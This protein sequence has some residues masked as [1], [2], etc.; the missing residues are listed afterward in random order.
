M[1][2][3]Y[4]SVAVAVAAIGTCLF[5]A[6]ARAQFTVQTQRIGTFMAEFPDGPN[7]PVNRRHVLGTD[8][9]FTATWRGQGIMLF[10]DSIPSEESPP[11]A[12]VS[13]INHDDAWG[14][15]S[16]ANSSR[17]AVPTFYIYAKTQR[18]VTRATG[19]INMAGAR[20]PAGI[21]S[22]NESYW[23]G[24]F[25]RVGAF[26]TCSN[27]SHCQGL[28]CDTGLR[29]Y[30]PPSLP[31]LVANPL[32]C[33][34]ANPACAQATP[35]Q[36]G[37]CRDTSTSNPMRNFVAP[38]TP[39]LDTIGVYALSQSEQRRVL[40]VATIHQFGPNSQIVPTSYTTVP[41]LTNKF[42]NVTMRATR[43]LADYRVPAAEVQNDNTLWVWGRPSYWTNTT[44]SAP[45]DVFLARQYRTSLP[46]TGDA[47]TVLNLVYRKSDGTWSTNQNDAAKLTATDGWADGVAGHLNFTFIEGA[48][49]WLMTYGGGL[50]TAFDSVGGPL[51]VTL[52]ESV[53]TDGTI[54]MRIADNPW[55]PWSAPVTALGPFDAS[56]CHQLHDDNLGTGD[57]C[58]GNNLP[59]SQ[60]SLIFGPGSLYGANV[61]E[62]WTTWSAATRNA[63][64][65]WVV[66]TWNPY[67]VHQMKSTIH[68]P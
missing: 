3:T 47:T 32:I 20:T 35:G 53:K 14:F 38:A 59:P 34:A 19:D 37:I 44:A 65:G 13:D 64:I 68:I 8:M 52:S 61:I 54:K 23:W 42:T 15:W 25:A 45:A 51:P 30:T 2:H 41:W 40:T 17:N 60:F 29:A 66:S 56:I 5:A 26:R 33:V 50:P 39:Y 63:E 9:G 7:V 57:R 22:F 21:A 6:G 12:N 62:G 24:L 67:E 58:G 1:K 28:A 46:A 31:G 48:N 18:V 10:G 16:M 43:S 36:T 55:G 11:A 4:L 49:K 27:D